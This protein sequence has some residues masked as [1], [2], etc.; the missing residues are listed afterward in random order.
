[1]EILVAVPIH[2]P[3]ELGTFVS[4]IKLANH[5]GLHNYHF[6]F[7]QNSLV[8][9]AREML[10]DTFMKS[11]CEAIMFIDSDMTFSEASVELLARHNLPF[12]TAKA[13]K[14]SAPFQP[15]FYTEVAIIDGSPRLQVPLD[16]PDCLL[17][18]EGAG[19]AC[20]LIKKEV[21]EKIKKP[22]FEPLPVLGEDLSF[23]MKVKEAGIPM[24]CDTTVEF[25]HI[26]TEAF[27]EK[28]FKEHLKKYE[29][30]G[31]DLEGLFSK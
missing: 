14:R 24:F 5:R 30:E 10:L 28:H 18:I 1:M 20:V 31:N 23:C 21:F 9:T 16:Y 2:R 27:G 7:V 4:F 25:G 29:E 8:Y 15:C 6:S 11:K 17:P 22:H 19:M 26:G 12:V 3:V 13:F